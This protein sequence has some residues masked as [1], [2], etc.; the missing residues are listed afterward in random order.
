MVI[1]GESCGGLFLTVVQLAWSHR[2]SQNDQAP[3]T[4]SRRSTSPSPAARH[5][6]DR[7]EVDV[8]DLIP[9]T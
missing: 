6:A 9:G 3:M 7:V 2:K 8:D 4:R 1:F 5:P